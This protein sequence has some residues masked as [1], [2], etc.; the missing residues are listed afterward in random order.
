[1]TLSRTD[2]QTALQMLADIRRKQSKTIDTM[3]ND[4]RQLMKFE[5]DL[6]DLASAVA[7][8]GSALPSEPTSLRATG[9]NR[10][11]MEFKEDVSALRGYVDELAT[12]TRDAKDYMAD[13][14]TTLD[15]LQTRIEE[16]D[17]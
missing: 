14:K 8:F 4:W 9:L 16:S 15:I 10:D 7:E 6:G 2:T 1:M 3:R 5:A 13:I 17:L 12:M 11:L